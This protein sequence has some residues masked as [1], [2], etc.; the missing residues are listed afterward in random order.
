MGGLKAEASN[1]ISQLVPYKSF[2]S[3][4]SR[5]IDPYTR[6][7]EG[8]V[9]G[10]TSQLPGLSMLSEP[11]Y[12][13]VTQQPSERPNRFLNSLS[14]L[15]ATTGDKE[16]G[17]MYKYLGS[18]KRAYSNLKQLPKEEAASMFNKIIKYDKSFAKEIIEVSKEVQIGVTNKDKQL[19]SVSVG[20]GE[21]AYKLASEFKKLKT[22]EE[23]IK[24]WDDYVK[25]GIITKEVA[26]QLVNL[27]K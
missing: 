11:Y 23:K 19:M 10:V 4:L 14:P 22:K 1:T 25:K 20:D 26:K 7:S 24:L 21:R 3:W 9:E 12:N 6:K 17:D 8:I 5:M 13:P 27:L 18:A 15:R 2:L 16:I